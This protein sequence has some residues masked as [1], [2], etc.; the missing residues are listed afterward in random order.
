MEPICVECRTRMRCHK[1]GRAVLLVESATSDPMQLWHGDEWACPT[2]GYHAVLGFGRVPYDEPGRESFT[3]TVAV[4]RLAN[5]L[6][7]VPV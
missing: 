1:N 3:D 5:N 6:I 4:E 2:C 7:E